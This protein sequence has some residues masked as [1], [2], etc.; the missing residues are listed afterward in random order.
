MDPQYT[1]FEY[2]YRDAG[3]YKSWGEL[4]LSGTSSQYEAD[5]LIACLETDNLFVTEQVG[6]P[7]LYEN[8][9]A[10]SGGKTEDDH[11]F[12]EFIQL[13]PAAANEVDD[14]KAFATVGELL[15]RFKQAC[16]LWDCRKSPN[17]TGG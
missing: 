2:L 1:I 6:I 16:Q 11:A 13:R 12:H 4:L 17:C 3:N 8:L 10:L 7:P 5:N 9:W 15:Q 14:M